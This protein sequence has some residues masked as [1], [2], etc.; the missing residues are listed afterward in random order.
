MAQWLTLPHA[1]EYLDLS[2]DAFRRLVREGKFPQPDRACG[3]RRPRWNR[4][5]L[6]SAMRST[7]SSRD[8]DLAVESWLEKQRHTRRAANAR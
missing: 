6:D 1:A 4:E 5:A 8:P 3:P 7:P 2:V